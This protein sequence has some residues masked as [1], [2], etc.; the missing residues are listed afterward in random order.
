MTAMTFDTLEAPKRLRDAGLDE[1]AA[2]AIVELV[3]QSTEWPDISHLATKA[4]IRD[5]ATKA[6]LRDM[7]VKED[8]R[9]TNAVA[10]EMKAKIVAIRGE[11]GMTELRLRADISEKLRLQTLALMGAMTALVGLATAIVKLV[12]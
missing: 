8:L 1:R 5:M 10:S 11:I 6:D 7:V 2:E 4:D 3:Q 9:A 12:P